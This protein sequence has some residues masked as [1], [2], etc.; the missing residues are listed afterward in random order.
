MQMGEWKEFLYA[1]DEDLN[2]DEIKL[3]M[4]EV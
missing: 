4:R 1:I 2:K 3:A